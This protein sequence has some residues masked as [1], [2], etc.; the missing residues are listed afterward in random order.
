MGATDQMY[1]Q[2]RKKPTF[3]NLA[4]C[5][6]LALVMT[7]WPPA[8]GPAPAA[9]DPDFQLDPD[10]GLAPPAPV[11]TPPAP[12][13]PV[14]PARDDRPG[15]VGGRY[16]AAHFGGKNIAIVHDASAYGK[17]LADTA[18]R[19]LNAAGQQEVLYDSYAAD[20]MD[21]TALIA[22]LKQARID[23]V[24]VGGLHRDVALIAREMRWG[25]MNTALMGGDAL[26]TDEFWLITGSAG[27]G[28]LMAAPGAVYRWSNGTYRQ[29]E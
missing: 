28:T 27:E 3:R 17:D 19:A 23:A 24:F 29:I 6:F 21:H 14:A 22:K 15:S 8:A 26:A 18:K 10:I 20:Q 11:A 7:T 25:G 9:E 16:L 13:A 4:G 1:V 2:G 12:A 5:A